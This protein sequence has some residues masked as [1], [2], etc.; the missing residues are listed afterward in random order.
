MHLAIAV[1]TKSASTKSMDKSYSFDK[2]E[3]DTIFGPTTNDGI[4]PMQQLPLSLQ[5][6]PKLTGTSKSCYI[7]LP[8][9][10]LTDMN[11]VSWCR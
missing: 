4:K 3:L 7:K 11:F 1:P 2:S 10:N 5:N 8:Q 6:L 9:S